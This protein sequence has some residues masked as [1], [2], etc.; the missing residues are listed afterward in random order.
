MPQL[1]P[2]A[3]VPAIQLV[4][5]ETTK[6]ELLEIYLEVYKL[7]RLLGPPP[8]EPA[9]LEEV[10]SSLP[11]QQRCKEEKTPAATAQQCA[12]NPH[13]SRS[14][15][16]YQT[17]KDDPVERSLAMVHEAHQKALAAI[18][19]LEKEIERLNHTWAHSQSRGQPKSRDH[20]W[21]SQEGRKKRHCQVQF[22]DEPA[23][24]QSANPKTQPGEEA[25][26]GRDS[27]LEELPELKPMVASF[28]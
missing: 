21:Q 14:H 17:R 27:D 12:E 24:R 9:I 22:A 10:L 3:G 23:P 16:P 5:L 28:L 4:G 15:T 13:S 18:S 6:E 8:G 20:Q 25:S 1:N 11:D 2:E 7:H 19:T 26:K